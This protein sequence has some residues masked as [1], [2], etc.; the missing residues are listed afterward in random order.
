MNRMR[1]AMLVLSLSVA[2]CSQ[3]PRYVRPASPVPDSFKEMRG[4]KLAEPQ[5]QTEKG[6]WW[7]V[8]NDP[9]L[10]YLEEQVAVSNQNV[11]QAEA[12][13]RQARALT[14]ATRAGIYPTVNANVSA[15]RS[16]SSSNDNTL[17]TSGKSNSNYRA[18]VDAAWEL[19]LW[20]RVRD[21][22]AA[23]R[24]SAQA[25]AADS[26]AVRLSMQA[27][28]AQNY[29]Q[30]RVIDAQKRLF[31]ETMVAYDRSLQLARNQYA[32]GVVAKAD[33]I[34]AETT[35]RSTQAQAADLGAQRAVL[36][37]A[38]A[39]LIGMP[40][41]SFSLEAMDSLAPLP[42]V[43]SAVP[44]QLLERRPDI[45][46]A[47]RRVAAANAQI[48]VAR[49]AYFPALTLNGSGGFQSSSVS[50]WL[51][52]PNRF[53]S[54]GPALAQTLFDAGARRAQTEQAI[55]AYDASV[56]G[57][58]QTVLSGFQEVEDQLATLRVL[59]AEAAIQDQ[60]VQSARQSVT[61]MI[62]QYKSGI[63]NYANVVTVQTSA[64]ANE[65]SSVDIL[66]RRLVAS[67]QLIK[68]LG[69]GWSA[70]S[71]QNTASKP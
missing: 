2:A 52:L 47:E 27:A 11:L 19:D 65:R 10:S 66:G 60:A 56:A 48:G 54:V 46:S 23:S 29:F 21:S 51:T 58:R 22:V 69:G 53:W 28:L 57:Y 8:F 14:D 49:S 55:A 37:H 63:V 61:L 36:E 26:A 43:P 18:S 45:A 67:V 9:L 42:P 31:D 68:A 4:W 17:I 32:S 25:S 6:K 7:A 13:Y 59:E 40:A 3:A 71:L 64:L 39:V 20:G 44:S 70:E 12:V 41:S 5:D 33:V 34:L 35:L 24:A 15:T 38:I 50:D 16:R 30:L 62:N 1:T